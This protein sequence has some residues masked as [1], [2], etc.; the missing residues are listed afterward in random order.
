MKTVFTNAMV[1]HVWAQQSQEEGRNS[2]SS[3]FFEGPTIYSYGRH[4]FIGHFA[5]PGVVLLNSQTYSVTT[6]QHQSA[7]RGAIPADKKCFYVPTIDNHAR[8]IKSY[9]DAIAINARK[10]KNAPRTSWQTSLENAK[11]WIN[12]AINKNRELL[13]YCHEFGLDYNL[14]WEDI[15][16]DFEL[17]RARKAKN[18][19]KYNSP[20]ESE[21]R[22][23][24]KVSKEKRERA[25]QIYSIRKAVKDFRANKNPFLYIGEIP[26]L[27]R[28]DGDTIK[29]SRNATMPAKFAKNIWQ[30]VKHCKSEKVSFVPNGKTLHAGHFQVNEIDI[31]G[32]LRAGCHSIKYGVLKN[33]ARQLGLVS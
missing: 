15:C 28:L 31:N 11:S 17:I 12:D 23:R 16:A 9:K 4:F 13:D 24:A 7:T 25:K 22:R 3:I 33:M 20:K 19:D 2:N 29:T 5:K 26:I 10:A 14:N 32:D 27:L 18:D 21:K 6:S 1:A 8:N 30:M